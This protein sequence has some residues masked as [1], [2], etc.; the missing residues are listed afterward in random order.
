MNSIG[1]E[2]HVVA[3]GV[4]GG[5]KL[6]GVLME[7]WAKSWVTKSPVSALSGFSESVDTWALTLPLQHMS[8]R[9]SNEA[10]NNTNN[11]FI[12]WAF[13]LGFSEGKNTKKD[14]M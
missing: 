4:A 10:N 7:K 3:G 9:Q 11:F 5:S 14:A 13:Y 8:M 12:F 1:A 6:P 2:T